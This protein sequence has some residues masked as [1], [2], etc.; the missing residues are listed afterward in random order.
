MV[1]A[2]VSEWWDRFGDITKKD[3]INEIINGF[4]GRDPDY[5]SGWFAKG[6]GSTTKTHSLDTTHC[7]VYIMGDDTANGVGYNNR[8]VGHLE[9]S[10]GLRQG[11]C[12]QNLTTTQITV[13]RGTNDAYWDNCRIMMWKL[14]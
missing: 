9:T 1:V 11:A 6:T 13:D 4:L 7:F 2:E 10:G 5:D 3:K 12:W 14:S 8:F